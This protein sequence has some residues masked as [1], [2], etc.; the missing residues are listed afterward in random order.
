MKKKLIIF[1]IGKISEV[2]SY[3]A[4]EECGYDVAAYTVDDTYATTDTFNGVPVIAFSKLAAAYP[5]A[6][7]D[8]F[9]ALGYHDLNR[10][11]AARCADAKKMGY[12]LVS[13]IS[14]KAEI[15][16]D[17]KVGANCFIMPPAIIHPRVAIGDNCFIWSGALVGHHSKLDANCWLTSGCN[18]GGNVT[19][20]ANTFV[21]INAT[22]SH[23]VTVGSE[24]FLGANVLVT[25][26]LT[27]KQVVIAENHKP[28][29]MNSDQFLRLSKFSSL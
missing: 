17:V 22:V 10:L 27:D 6:Q 26:N 25:K 28:I 14:P 3:Y 13:I 2:V 12:E 7:Y 16:R 24:C 21:A 11:R 8:L 18:I 20:G 5:P 9:I 29:K 4:S 15:P 1:G 23:S 19:L